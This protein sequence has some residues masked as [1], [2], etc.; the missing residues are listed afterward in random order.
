MIKPHDSPWERM[1][2]IL[3]GLFSTNWINFKTLPSPTLRCPRWHTGRQNQ[4]YC[5]DSLVFIQRVSWSLPRPTPPHTQWPLHGSLGRKDPKLQSVASS[6]PG[7]ADDNYRNR[8]A[9]AARCQ[10]M[11]DAIFGGVWSGQ[12]A[13][14]ILHG[15]RNVQGKVTRWRTKQQFTSLGRLEGVF[16]KV[17]W[18]EGNASSLCS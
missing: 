10:S 16:I 14:W 2:E 7:S 3:N 11:G 5:Y 18:G 12:H 13:F 1:N 17:L 8:N 9:R 15:V 6:C 4:K